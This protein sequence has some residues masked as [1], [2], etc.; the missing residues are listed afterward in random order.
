MLSGRDSIMARNGHLH[1]PT[2]KSQGLPILC[3][4]LCAV[5][6][7][8]L[9][10]ASEE[11]PLTPD[12]VKEI[13][14]RNRS[15]RSEDGL[16]LIV[17]DRD[18]LNGADA[19][20]LCRFV[21]N[22]RKRLSTLLGIPLDGENFAVLIR[23]DSLPDD[24]L[25]TVACAV[26]PEGRQR[27][28]LHIAGLAEIDPL[29]VSAALCGGYLRADALSSG[30]PGEV[31]HELGAFPY[32]V[33]FGTGAA[34]LLDVS[35]RQPDAEH[36]IALLEEGHLPS[37]S[38]L[39]S[40]KDS[41]ASDDG[42]VAAQLVAWALSNGSGFGTFRNAILARN[43]WHPSLLASSATGES[44]DT[45]WRIWLRHRKWAVLTPGTSHPAFVR[46]FRRLLVLPTPGHPD[47]ATEEGLGVQD[48]ILA[49]IPISAFDGTDGITPE[50]I[51]RNRASSWAPSAAIALAG[52]IQRA[53]AGHG[54]DVLATA[55]AFSAFFQSIARRQ[56]DSEVSRLLDEAFRLLDEM[57]SADEKENVSPIP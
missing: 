4:L 32:P 20:T 16:T 12:R 5:L 51:Y 30:F 40:G 21:T 45:A 29:D 49:E 52:R 55:N 50:A 28:R 41:L 33:W 57:E 9:P 38:A 47:A 15:V 26:A 7:A 13:L 43:G 48:E 14:E 10:C 35:L 24:S 44:Q 6:F 11:S 34:R 37:L 42:A 3:L 8:I 18:N 23:V 39:A 1:N 53:A 36:T 2:R 56:P 54:P 25:P 27:I 31:G 46:R 19:M 17:G 22:V